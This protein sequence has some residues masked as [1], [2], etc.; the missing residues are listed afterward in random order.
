MT[1]VF[2]KKGSAQPLWAGHPWVFAQ[3]I[4][5][6]EGSPTGGTEVRVL[7][8]DGKF[9]GRG[10]YSP[11]SALPVRIMSHH[12]A[13]LDNRWLGDA[14]ESASRLRLTLGFPSKDDT[15]FRLLHSEGD[16]LPGLICDVF[17]DALA[18]QTLTVGMHARKDEIYG[19]LQRVT[20]AKRIIEIGVRNEKEGL[21]YDTSVVRGMTHQPLEF[22][23]RGLPLRLEET[24]SQKTGYYFDQRDNR[25]HIAS[26]AKGR[27]VLDLC[28]YMGLFSIRALKHGATQALAVDSSMPALMASHA[29][30]ASLGVQDRF[31][32]QKN[33]IRDA[34]AALQQSKSGF[35]MII[36]DPPKLA[37]TIKH[38]A[39]A[40]QLYK[41][42][43]QAAMKLLNPGGLMATFSCS[44]SMGFEPFLR[45]L[46]LAMRDAKRELR[47]VGHYH[48]ASDHPISPAFPEGHYLKGVLM[49]AK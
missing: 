5:R 20:H 47:I 33:D 6:I 30:A 4:E 28:S 11:K 40:T 49:E 29:L 46:A 1:Q 27:T 26:M 8:A 38:L 14:I 9:I 44:S 7:D 19:H 36:L 31:N 45:M 3:A 13:P 34:M 18:V 2:I 32:T 23:E 37:P 35:D 10:F 42:L 12:D 25:V 16:G 21:Y 22:I 15:G 48:Q 43:N 24:L 39:K 41:Q 17:G